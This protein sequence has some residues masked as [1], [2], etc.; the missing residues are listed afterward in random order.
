M[1]STSL[2]T[3]LHRLFKTQSDNRNIGLKR[4]RKSWGDKKQMLICEM[5]FCNTQ[6]PQRVFIT[7]T[8]LY[9]NKI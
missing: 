6:N 2:C 1:S 3:K 5:G 7:R 8:N 9:I 4:E